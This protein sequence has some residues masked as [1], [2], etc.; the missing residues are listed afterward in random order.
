MSMLKRFVKAL[1]RPFTRR[2]FARVDTRVGTAV[3]PLQGRL[4]ALERDV[5]ALKDY[6]PVLLNTISSQN[7]AA[8]DFARS[9]THLD[10]R[11]TTVATQLGE[12]I[13]QVEERGEFIRREM[14]F[15]MRYGGRQG[16]G[17]F[18]QEPQVVSP[19]KVDGSAPIRV[20]LGCGHLPKEGY[21][22]VDGRPLP[23]VD[24]VADV[25]RLPLAEGQVEEIFSAHLLEHFPVEQLTRSLLPYWFSLLRPGGR[26]VAVVPDADTMVREYAA[27]RYGFDELRLVTFG[28]QEYDGD[29]HF[30]MFSH[31]SLAD[32]LRQ[33]GFHDVRMTETGRR[34]GACYE[35]EVAACKPETA[36]PAAP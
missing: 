1:L 28:E 5:A 3:T 36:A 15:E 29:F 8:R 32:L 31:E 7:A 21:V 35:M 33:V 14:L 18:Q 23:G 6:V 34:N 25:R 4:D 10:E 2:L 22:N 27:G 17:E 9:R 11:I 19:E 30:T 13:G 16:V 26:F 12:R 20:N 24:V